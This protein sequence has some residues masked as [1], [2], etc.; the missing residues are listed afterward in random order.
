MLPV[1]FPGANTNLIEPVGMTEEQCGRLPAWSGKMEG[2]HVYQVAY[3]P[4]LE[5]LLAVQEGRPVFMQA[6]IAPESGLFVRLSTVRHVT[7]GTLFVRGLTGWLPSASE[8][9][10][11][12]KGSYVWITILA[13]EFPP[14]SVWTNDKE[15]NPNE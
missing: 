9:R 12:H 6:M 3:K 14:I 10:L 1:N 11:L 2:A 4:N 15:G 13:K 5:D 8:A 7:T